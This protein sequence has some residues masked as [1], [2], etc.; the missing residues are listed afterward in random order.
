V[1]LRAEILNSVPFPLQLERKNRRVPQEIGPGGQPAVA[2]RNWVRFR[3]V[4]KATSAL[5]PSDWS[6]EL[7]SFGISRLRGDAGSFRFVLTATSAL[8]PSDW[9]AELGSF[10]IF[11]FARQEMVELGSCHGGLRSFPASIEAGIPRD[12]LETR[13]LFEKPRFN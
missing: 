10:G 8:V 9:S 6:A 11:R 12:L 3:F 4:S 2:E 13:D 1:N 7:G 5:V